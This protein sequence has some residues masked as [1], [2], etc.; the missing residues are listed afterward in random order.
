MHAVFLR[1]VLICALALVSPLVF[2]ID[3]DEAA[4]RVQQSTGGRVLAVDASTKNGDPVYLVRVLT[5]DGEVRVVVIDATSGAV[6]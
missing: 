6:R 4:T 3:R 1:V 5:P 2:A